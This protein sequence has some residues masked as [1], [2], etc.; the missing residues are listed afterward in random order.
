L[1]L[2]T[3]RASGSPL[4]CRFGIAEGSS[5]LGRL[6]LVAMPVLV[7]KIIVGGFALA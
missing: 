4:F 3:T 5:K 7:S 1:K 2:S 6:F